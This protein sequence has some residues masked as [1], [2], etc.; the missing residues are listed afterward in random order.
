MLTPTPVVFDG[1]WIVE[2]VD[3]SSGKEDKQA[4]QISNNVFSVSFRTGRFKGQ[5][6]GDID[7]SGNLT[8]LVIVGKTMGEAGAGQLVGTIKLKAQYEQ[9]GFEGKAGA[10]VPTGV[11]S[12]EYKEFKVKLKRSTGSG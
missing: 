3:L 9:S 10:W 12:E 6:S 4:A 1:K 7:E 8:A 5:I 11:T 2:T